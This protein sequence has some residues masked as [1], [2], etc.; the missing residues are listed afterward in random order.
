[1]LRPNNASATIAN[2]HR[3]NKN[4][5]IHDYDNKNNNNEKDDNNDEFI[6]RMNE[7]LLLYYQLKNKTLDLTELKN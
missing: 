6:N 4:N 7:S 5:M 2:R 1:M 3:S